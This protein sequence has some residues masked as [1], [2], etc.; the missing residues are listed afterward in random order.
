MNCI[1]VRVSFLMGHPV[2]LC[3]RRRKLICYPL[4][5]A[6][7]FKKVR[8][9]LGFDRC[10]IIISGAA[11]TTRETIEFFMSLDMPIMEGYGMSESSGRIK[12]VITVLFTS[13]N[14]NVFS[15]GRV[16]ALVNSE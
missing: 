14:G 16:L 1:N 10:R 5:K 9:T 15:A 12:V 7:V 13:F 4:A 8:A 2:Y 6:L 11:P 3:C